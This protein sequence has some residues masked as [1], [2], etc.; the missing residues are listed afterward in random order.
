MMNGKVPAPPRSV[1]EPTATAMVY[2]LDKDS[3]GVIRQ[4]LSGLSVKSVQ[5][6]AG[7]I[8]GAIADL[9]KRPS[10]RLLVVDISNIEDPISAVSELSEVCEP[11]TGVIVTGATNDVSLYRELRNTGIAEYF[12]KPLVGNLVARA[13]NAILTGAS[14]ERGIRTGKLVLVLGV[15]GGSGTTTI[16]TRLAWHLAEGRKRPVVLVD[17]DLLTGDASLQLNVKAQHALRE[18]LEHPER[19]DDLFLERAVTHVSRRFNLLASL[20]PLDSDIGYH[21]EGA[22]SLISTLLRK[23]RYVFVDLPADRAAPLPSLLHLPCVCLLVSDAGLASARDVARWRAL[24][25]TDTPER[26]VLHILNKSDAPSGLPLADFVRA[27]GRTPDIVIPYDREVAIA[28]RLG[29]REVEKCKGFFRALAPALQSIAGEPAEPE[30]S[31]MSR[32]FG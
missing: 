1:P 8:A 6:G 24:M 23:Y 11:G 7:G 3:E 32:I 22:L 13:C 28:S 18:A 9:A 4:S 16:A 10:P 17:L 15:R 21:E 26:T 29:I 31:L 12:F 2:A 30:T 19:V 20:E 27:S 14:D 5:F 25:G